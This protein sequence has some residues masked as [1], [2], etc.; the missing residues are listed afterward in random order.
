MRDYDL[1]PQIDELTA[2]LLQE[3]DYEKERLW[4][5]LPQNYTKY[6]STSLNSK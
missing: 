1:H 3:R 2:N 5:T 6:K 4:I